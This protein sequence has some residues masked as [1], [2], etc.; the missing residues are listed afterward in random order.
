M[1]TTPINHVT[2]NKL[3]GGMDVSSKEWVCCFRNAARQRREVRVPAFDMEALTREIAVASEKLGTDKNSLVMLHEAGRDGFSVHRALILL[4]I[5]S[6]LADPGSFDTKRRKGKKRKTDKLD[7]R[8]LADRCYL[9][10]NGE[11][12]FSR[13]R[14]PTV[15]D[16]DLRHINRERESLVKKRTGRLNEIGSLFALHGLSFRGTEL[17]RTSDKLEQLRNASGD[18]I[19]PYLRRR[20]A[21]AFVRLELLDRQVEE[22]EKERDEALAKEVSQRVSRETAVMARLKGVG[23]QTAFLMSVEFLWR[24]F[25]RSK[26]VGAAT[27]L[28]GT[29][30]DTGDRDREQGIEKCGNKRVRTSLVQLGWRWLRWQPDSHLTQW[31]LRKWGNGSKRQRRIGIVAL[32]RRLAIAL[33]R[34]VKFGQVPAGALMKEA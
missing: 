32:A 12:P 17:R 25:E 33:W 7:A 28:V 3:F 22:L 1:T 31:Y 11:K 9:E 8:K 5:E 6:V 16:E 34:L 21:R 19:P 14:C 18:L 4:G 26:Q 30:F 24:D 23:E 15:E 20:I 27:G 2:T 29:P 13:V 10:A